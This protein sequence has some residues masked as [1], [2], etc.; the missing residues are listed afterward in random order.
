MNLLI[1]ENMKPL[2]VWITTNC[3]KFFS[4]VQSLSRARLFATPWIAACQ[5]S[6]S[7]TNSWSSLRLMS[8]ESVMPSSHLILCRPLLLPASESFPMSQ[9]FAWGG[10][11]TG[12]SALASVLPK[13]TQDGSPLEWTGWISLQSKGLSRVFSNTT[14]QKH[15]FFGTQLSSVQFSHPY[16]TT[17]KTIALTRQTFVG[18]VMSLLLNML[19][20]L[21]ITFLPRSRRLLISWLQSPSAV[22][23]EPPK[24]KSDTVS[25]VSPS[26]HNL[27]LC[28]QNSLFLSAVCIFHSSHPF[29]SFL[30][31][32][33]RSNCKRFSRSLFGDVWFFSSVAILAI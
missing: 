27:R 30:P 2:T 22:I 26:G 11:S 1:N 19:S 8:I 21:V 15:Q 9:L 13:N 31:Q 18:R 3:G 29:W 16:M 4:S 24:I 10:Q 28:P 33:C 17:G 23:L 7:I 20:R 25:T 12:V 6:R 5:A 14:V 32:T